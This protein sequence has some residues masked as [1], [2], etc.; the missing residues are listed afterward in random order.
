MITQERL[1]GILLEYIQDDLTERPDEVMDWLVQG[2]E[3]AD[4]VLDAIGQAPK[5]FAQLAKARGLLEEVST[6]IWNNQAGNHH[7]RRI[8][9]FLDRV[10][11]SKPS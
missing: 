10:G 3:E 4:S 8:D 7:A 5:T 2:P 6:A 9:Q 11:E 1:F